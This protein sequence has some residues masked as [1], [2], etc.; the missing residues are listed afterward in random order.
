MALFLLICLI[1]TCT[2]IAAFAGINQQVASGEFTSGFWTN[3]TSCNL[4]T[5]KSSYITPTSNNTWVED[6]TWG[7][8]F[9][10]SFSIAAPLSIVAGVALSLLYLF[11][12]IHYA[13]RMVYAS[14]LFS[15]T[16][17]GIICIATFATGAWPMGFI[18]LIVW[19][20]SAGIFWWIRGDYPLVGRFLST[21][22]QGLVTCHGIVWAT[23]VL[24]ITGVLILA[25]YLSALVASSYNGTVISNPSRSSYIP[26]APK[27]DVATC[28]N[29]MLK[30]VPCCSLSTP[31]WISFQY[32]IGSV[33][34]IWTTYVILELRLY[35]TADTIAQW[36]FSATPGSIPPS[37]MRAVKHGL[38]S[39]FGSVCFGAAI[40][41][42]IDVLREG[43][44]RRAENAQGWMALVCCIINCVGQCLLAIIE[45]F[46]RFVSIATAIT[47]LAFIPAGKE[48]W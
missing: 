43:L 29:S 3:S 39:S 4:Q 38:T 24:K 10:V 1:A 46:T 7:T 22:T 18:L 2:S 34:L 36:Y 21:A 44:K 16:V 13:T 9:L 15:L 8:R 12:F 14:I 20:I 11:L 23:I 26:T 42:I 25:F 30:P 45:Q 6:K 41:A 28:Y 33:M 40:L 27:S 48:L 17:T 35:I 32:F 31:S 37:T 5:Y 47:G 19:L